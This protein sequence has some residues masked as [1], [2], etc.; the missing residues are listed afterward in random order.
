MFA[1]FFS[2]GSPLGRYDFN[3]LE[4]AEF[5][6]DV[7]I[8]IA[9]GLTAGPWLRGSTP[10]H[11]KPAP[12]TPKTP[13]EHFGPYTNAGYLLF[14]WQKPLFSLFEEVKTHT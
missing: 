8:V 2:G 3:N 1:L 7:L 9:P 14:V 6:G 4:F 11:S 10:A 5:S 12:L 13:S